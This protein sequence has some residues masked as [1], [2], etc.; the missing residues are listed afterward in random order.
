MCAYYEYGYRKI[1][2]LEWFLKTEYRQLLLSAV[3]IAFAFSLRYIFR[4]IAL[5]RLTLGL[6]YISAT[7]LA[8]ILA[9]VPH[10]LFHRFVARKLGYYAR[11]RVWLLGLA[12]AIIFP[13]LTFGGFI[14]AAPGA[15]VV[16]PKY[17]FGYIDRKD[18]GLIAVAGPLANLI[19]GYVAMI[20]FFL[21]RTFIPFYYLLAITLFIIMEINLWL[22]MFNLIPFPPLDGSKV[23]A[24][25]KTMWLFAFILAAIPSF[26]ILYG[27]RFL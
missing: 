26:I 7:V 15:V 2:I 9:F 14:F 17:P 19:V 13:L 20:A 27:L 4:Y 21:V 1:R 16:Y 24:W 23:F 8:V 10:E 12:L 22:A 5:G 11:Y 3:V 25:S 6:E 18:Y